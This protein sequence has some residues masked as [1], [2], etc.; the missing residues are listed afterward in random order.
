MKTSQYHLINKN[1]IAA[2]MK[3]P[4]KIYL[5]NDDKQTV[6]AFLFRNETVTEGDIRQMQRT[7]L[8]VKE[9]ERQLYDDFVLSHMK[10]IDEKGLFAFQTKSKVILDKAEHIMNDMFH[11]PEALGHIE[12]VKGIVDDLVVTILD[13]QFTINALLELAAHDY[14]THTHSINVSIYALSLGK[15]LKLNDHDLHILGEAALMH[16]LGKSKIREDIINKNGRLTHA[17]FEYM[18]HHSAWSYEIAIKMGVTDEK[19]LDAIRHHHEKLN[20]SGYPDHLKGRQITLFSRILCICDIFDALTTKRSYKDPVS[21]FKTLAMMKKEMTNEID[22]R[23]LNSF[24]L[25]MQGK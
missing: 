12:E 3:F 10:K 1:F 5:L 20:G 17:E 2:G 13:K 23:L 22:E 21:T 15:H 4:F 18:Q 16:D 14:Y 11:N 6:S 19:I 25:M 8:Y 24:I 7:M 9:E